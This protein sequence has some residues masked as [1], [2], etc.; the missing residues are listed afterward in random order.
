[1]SGDEATRWLLIA[2]GIPRVMT[3]KRYTQRELDREVEADIAIECTT[4]DPHFPDS[5]PS[6]LEMLYKRRARNRRANKSA[7][8]ARRHNRR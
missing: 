4:L 8:R 1:V 5:R 7:R 2:P 6:N 3:L